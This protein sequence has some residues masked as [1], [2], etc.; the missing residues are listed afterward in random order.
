MNPSHRLLTL[1]DVEAA[2]QVVAQAFVD[3]PLVAFILP[4]KTRRL[5]TLLKFA[6]VYGEINIKNQRGFGIGEPLQGVTYWKFPNQDSA[7]ISIKSL[8]KF[9]PF[10]FT[11]YPIGH[12]RARAI[13]ERIDSLHHKHADEPH[14]YLDNLG[15]LA[16]ARGK[17][18]SSELIRPF[19]EMA[20]SQ[21]VI[22]YTDTV[23][24]AN[25]SLY[26]HFGFQCVEASPVQGTDITVYALLRP[27][28]A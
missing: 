25:V 23:T 7:S 9:L 24:P 21:K 11:I 13:F 27:L 28:Q 6:R 26:E 5:K 2:A 4:N 8:G 22:A 15:V 3:D 1:S 14:F 17:G 16:S 18:L 20:D 10:L 19:L 12:F